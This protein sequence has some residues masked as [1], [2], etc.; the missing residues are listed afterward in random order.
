MN[1]VFD[2]KS[3]RTWIN[4]NDKLPDLVACLI[5][6]RS[7]QYIIDCI[8]HGN[9]KFTSEEILTEYNRQMEVYHD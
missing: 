4:K 5:K 2:K 9:P 7:I 3:N 6:E 1:K 8:Q